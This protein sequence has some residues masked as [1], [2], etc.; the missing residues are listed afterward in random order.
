MEEGL[1]AHF[2][3][4]VDAA[5]RVRTG[6]QRLGFEL[7]TPEPYASPLLTAVCGLP[8]MDVERLRRYLI[9][10]WQVMV[11]GGLSELRGRVFRVAHIGEAASEEYVDQ[12]LAGVEA[13]LRLR[14]HDV[15]PAPDEG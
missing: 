14:G 12:F 5:Q 2:Q 1:E 4:H 6:L 11:S 7:F 8:G 15:P 9:E 3:R 13:Y 10:E